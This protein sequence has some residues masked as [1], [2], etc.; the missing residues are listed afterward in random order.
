MKYILL[1]GLLFG[2]LL[3]VKATHIVGG[4]F[5]MKHNTNFSYTFILNL[6]FDK[7]NGNAEAF[8]P[9]ITVSIFEKVT[10]RRMQNFTMTSAS[11]TPVAY[12][13][14]ACTNA[15]LGTDK[16]VYINPNIILSAEVYNSPNGYYVVWE[17]CCRNRG[18]ANIIR[19]ENAGQTFYLEFPAVIQN[20]LRFINSSPE[21]FPPLSDYACLNDL[22][23][24]DF[25]GT[26]P[27]GDSLVYEMITP[28]NGFS[29]PPPGNARPIPFPGPYPLITWDAGLSERFQIPGAPT[30]AITRYTGRLT[31][32]PT[33]LGLFVFGVRVDEYRNKIKIGEIRRDFQLLVLDC[34]KNAKPNIFLREASKKTPYREGDVIIIKAT[35][36]RC[37]TIAATDTDPNEAVILTARPV[38]F[39]FPGSFIPVTQGIINRNN[40]GEELIKRSPFCITAGNSK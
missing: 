5:Q 17:R 39:N 6:Y 25:G 32:R 21:L 27:D 15:S 22:F 20:G 37:V 29:A 30:V 7:V 35:D 10:N 34:P 23:Y 36:N 11:R 13:S 14:I 31:I 1:I 40:Q 38:N 3:P 18:I 19:P 33:Q 26:D 8:D 12:T 9:S 24:Y 2:F 16:I 28:L 4:E